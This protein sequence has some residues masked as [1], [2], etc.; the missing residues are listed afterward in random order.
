MKAKLKHQDGHETIELP[1]VSVGSS[2]AMLR[3]GIGDSPATEWFP[4]RS[5]RGYYITELTETSV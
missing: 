3:T 4:F 5:E 2:G 1:V